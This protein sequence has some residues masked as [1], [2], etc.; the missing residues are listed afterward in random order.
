MKIGIYKIASL[1]DNRVYIGQSA[2]IDKRIKSHKEALIYKCHVNRYLQHFVNKYG[3]D[4]LAFS[5]VELCQKEQLNEREIYWIDFYKS[6]G[7]GFNLTAG[8]DDNPMNHAK[9]RKA[10]SDA[11][12]GHK[13]TKEWSAKIAANTDKS[14]NRAAKI[15]SGLIKKVYGYSP[16]TGV[17]LYECFGFREMSK[18]TGVGESNIRQC[19][20]GEF[21]IA[22]G[23]HFSRDFKAPEKVLIDVVY[24]NQ[25]EEYRRKM[26]L[27]NT[28]EGNP[29]Y[30]RKR[31]DVT[32]RYRSA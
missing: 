18:I 27:R 9:N 20:N 14:K 1:L 10:V 32:A 11:L 13:K 8:A 6:L 21:K 17:L 12:K 26:S 7:N 25:S 2:N 23:I 3:L 29:M 22:K 24:Q 5:E 16:T 19:Y 30:G 28:G 31:P 4:N 15:K